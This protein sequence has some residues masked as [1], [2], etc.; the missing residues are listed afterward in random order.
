M[1]KQTIGFALLVLFLVH[2]FPARAQQSGKSARIGLL[3]ATSPSNLAPRIG[4]LRQSLREL[5]YVEG[6]NLIIDERY[7]YG[8]L[9]RQLDQAKELARLKMDVIVTGGPVGT[10]AAR[11][12]T[13]TIPIV[14]AQD[15]DP[16][17]EG[18][19]ASLSRPGGN[20]T[21]FS[22]LSPEISG[23]KLELLKES[24]SNLSRVALVGNATEP[25]NAQKVSET[26]LA[27]SAFGIDV[28]YLELQA[29]EDIE[30]IFTSIKQQN[31][32]A[33]IVLRNPIANLIR[34]R[35]IDFMVRSRLP[36]ILAS[37]SWVKA[38]GLMYYGASLA[39]NWRRAAT[40]IHKIIEGAKP[41][42]LPVQ[43]PT[44]F[45]FMI[46]LKMAKQIGL[47]IPQWVLM[48]ADTVLQ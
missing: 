43:Q 42:D 41:A 46:N 26:R 13:S 9:E 37:P 18:F 25:G 38:G 6:K 30:A 24:V 17:G 44:K 47:T 5:G 1:I 33:L 35:I 32:R 45:D 29:R 40:Y 21:G 3:S 34:Q 2:G 23:K 39:D 7:A 15:S 16:V 14:M 8:K 48:R 11:A 27:G 36:G 28:Q 20:V 31:A 10:R 4:V 19:V 12:A 22:T